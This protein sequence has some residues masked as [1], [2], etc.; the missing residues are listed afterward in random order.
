MQIAQVMHRLYNR[1]QISLRIR[2][3]QED[4]DLAGDKACV[5]SGHVRC[6]T[7]PLM[8]N[9]LIVRAPPNCNLRGNKGARHRLWVLSFS[10]F[11][12]IIEIDSENTS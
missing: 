7:V 4:E 12:V 8:L 11:I 10:F 2:E 5:A 6:V 9:A 3:R 1:L